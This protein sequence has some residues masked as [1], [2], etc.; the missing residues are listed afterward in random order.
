MAS[1][2]Q[3]LNPQGIEIG[4]DVYLS[5]NV[6][7]NGLGGIVFEDQVVVGPYVT[8]SS[9]THGYKDSSFRF[10]GALSA[11]VRIGRGTWLAAHVSISY[12]VTIGSGCLITAN[13]AVTSD[14]PPGVVA[15]GVP[16]KKISQCEE[17]E[18]TLVSRSGFNTGA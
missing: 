15:G 14:I 5:Y 18:P 6:W 3:I 2:V 13:S 10:G 12:G 1:G 17:R 16:A 9:L 4:D 7:L 11:P 8:I